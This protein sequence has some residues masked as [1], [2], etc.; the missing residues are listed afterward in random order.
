[1]RQDG[2][3]GLKDEERLAKRFR[4]RI[5]PGCS[6]QTLDRNADDNRCLQSAAFYFVPQIENCDHCSTSSSAP[7]PAKVS[8]MGI[9]SA[10]YVECCWQMSTDK[11]S[12]HVP[13]RKLWAES[14]A[15][16]LL[17]CLVFPSLAPRHSPLY[18]I[19]SLAFP[20]SS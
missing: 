5:S 19:C 8:G 20:P 14:P 17:F 7:R 13:S 9:R 6:S 12:G 4:Y 2:R 1:M 11:V 16:A 10:I 18:F 15:P 3:A